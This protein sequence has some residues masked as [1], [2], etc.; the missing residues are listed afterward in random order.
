MTIIWV[1]SPPARYS[2][3]LPRVLSHIRII[4][5]VRDVGGLLSQWILGPQTIGST[6]I[7][8]ARFC[9]NSR[10][11]ENHNFLRIANGIHR[12]GH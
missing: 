9:G 10:T 7:W 4:D 2:A 3:T 1:G 5:V 8:N 11:S 6:K 12:F